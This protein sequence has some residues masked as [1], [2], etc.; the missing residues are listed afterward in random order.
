MNIS[1]PTIPTLM[2]PLGALII[3]IVAAYTKFSLLTLYGGA[4]IAL[5]TCIYCRIDYIVL[6]IS[7]LSLCWGNITIRATR[8]EQLYF[9]KAI[10]LQSYDIMGTVTSLEEISPTKRAV[11]LAPTV[12]ISHAENHTTS[13]IPVKL[14]LPTNTINLS[15]GDIIKACRTRPIVSQ[16]SIHRENFI[17]AI[18]LKEFGIIPLHQTSTLLANLKTL[19][20]RIRNAI[21]MRLQDKF[22]KIGFSLFSSLFLGKNLLPTAHI[23]P[24]IEQFNA[25]GISH[26]LARSGLHIIILL[27]LWH[28]VLRLAPIGF[29]IRQFFL[30]L[31][32]LLFYVLSFPSISFI[33][34]ILTYSIAR[35]YI[36]QKTPALSI[37]TIMLCGY[38]IL[39]YS[40]LALFSLSFQLSFSL[41]FF[42]AW[43][44]EKEHYEHSYF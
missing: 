42:I 1:L 21:I 4:C 10:A 35:F 36:F 18:P 22:S 7:L 37:H 2:L 20:S 43:L 39:I 44:Y 30:L 40:P 24:L 27:E 5:I 33:R 31:F 9:N 38:S 26:Y 14:Y 11:A 23:P 41:A 15:V 32:L 17:T 3:G 12:F 34:A 6:I 28:Y 8:A 16:R 19:L 29:S 13:S 25:W